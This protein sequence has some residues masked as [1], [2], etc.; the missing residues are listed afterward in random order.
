MYGLSLVI[1]L[2]YPRNVGPRVMCL[3]IAPQIPQKWSAFEARNKMAAQILLQ[4]YIRK[5]RDGGGGF[6]ERRLRVLHTI[7]VESRDVARRISSLEP[8]YKAALPSVEDEGKPFAEQIR[9]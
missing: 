2:T 8:R 9:R 5:G 3:T 4:T 7:S 1:V 6:V